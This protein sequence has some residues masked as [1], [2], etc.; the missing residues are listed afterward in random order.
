MKHKFEELYKL[1]QLDRQNS[2][3]SREITLT[4]RAKETQ[5]EVQE[6]IAGLEKEDFNN[7]K[8]EVGDVLWDLLALMVIA[9]EENILNTKEVIEK[10]ITKIKRRKPWLLEGKKLSK[11]EEY[12][13]WQEIKEDERNRS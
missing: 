13:L 7:F 10:I 4:G 2:E 11:E 8:E 12:K 5:K 6:M 3:W 1:L 9:E